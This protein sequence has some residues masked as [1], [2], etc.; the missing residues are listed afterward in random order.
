[1]NGEYE[2]RSERFLSWWLEKQGLC[3]GDIRREAEAEAD[4]RTFDVVKGVMKGLDQED[5]KALEVI[6]EGMAFTHSDNYQV[7]R[8]RGCEYRLNLSQAA[9]IKCLHQ[10]RLDGVPGCTA[11]NL[12]AAAGLARDDERLV[13]VFRN[14]KNGKWVR[15]PA[16]VDRMIEH[17]HGGTY[18]LAD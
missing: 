8:W 13:H 16:W 3:L 2:K 10:A 17:V 1:M 18:R 9:M 6:T 4:R 5:E 14:K 11:K 7:C 15:H 12:F